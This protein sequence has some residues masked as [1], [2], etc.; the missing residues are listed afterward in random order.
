MPAVHPFRAVRYTASRSPALSKLISPPYDV[1]SPELREELAARSPHN[2]IH[3]ILDKE[4]AGDGPDENKYVRAGRRW[5]E[6]MAEGVLRQDPRPAIYAI[7]QTFTGPD[8]HPLV[9]RGAVVNCRL[10]AYEEGII[11]PHEK[12]LSTALADRLEIL[13]RVKANLSAPFGLYE[14]D[15]REGHRTLAEAINSAGEPVSE[16]DSDDETHHRLWRIEEPRAIA[17]LREVLLSRTVFIADGHHRYESTLAYR[18]LVDQENPGLPDDAG[19]RYMMMTLCSMND[20]GLVIF[21][22]HRLVFGLQGFKLAAFLEQLQQYFEVETLLEDLRRPAGRAW[23]VS[24]LADH[25]G[26]STTFLMVSA[27]DKKGRILTARDDA[28][29]SRVSLPENVT[30]RDLDVTALHAIV[31]QHLLGLS[32]QA[33]EREENLRYEMDAGEVVNRTLSGEYQLGFLVNP[34]PM[35]QVAAVAESG[36]TMPQKSTFFYPKLATGLAMR[37]VHEKVVE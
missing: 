10:H 30:V 8:G 32:P 17:R 31:L 27:E 24:K 26:K 28:D 23:A 21:P 33:Q 19:H 7:E 5:N 13:K 3:V 1:V 6:W 36:D 9:R 2:I 25:C 22:T 11:L 34:T 12:T 16:A 20:P 35:W 15:R 18:D 29:F 4:R 37:I 14:D